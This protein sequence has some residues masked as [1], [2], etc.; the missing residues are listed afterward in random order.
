[1]SFDVRPSSQV[2]MAK[3]MLES[4]GPSDRHWWKMSAEER[5]ASTISTRS[6]TMN[7]FKRINLAPPRTQHWVAQG[8]VKNPEGF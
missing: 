1:M 2:S 4:A 6:T 3:S 5:G 8:Q 7:S